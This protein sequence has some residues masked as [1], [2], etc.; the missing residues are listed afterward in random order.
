MTR[1]ASDELA[2]A[3]FWYRTVARYMREVHK[4]SIRLS[5]VSDWA[6]ALPLLREPTSSAEEKRYEILRRYK[7]KWG[8]LLHAAINPILVDR[9]VRTK[10][11]TYRP[12]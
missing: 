3:Y 6:A 12:T 8:F 1:K 9:I 4:R 5:N 2:N 10:K 7:S 11:H